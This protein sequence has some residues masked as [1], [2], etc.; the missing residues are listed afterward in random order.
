MSR[1]GWATGGL[2]GYRERSYPGGRNGHAVHHPQRG[3]W[4]AC[5]DGRVLGRYASM[6]AAMERV[7]EEAGG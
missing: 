5:Y 1:S 6:Q 4:V 7:D 3:D 2:G